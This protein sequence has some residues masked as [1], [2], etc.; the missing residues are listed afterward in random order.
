[1]SLLPDY[2][3]GRSRRFT[4]RLSGW[5]VCLSR[6]RRRVLLGSFII[7]HQLS[8]RLDNTCHRT[9]AMFHITTLVAE[10]KS[11]EVVRYCDKKSNVF[12]F[13]ANKFFSGKTSQISD[14]LL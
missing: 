3:V 11:R 6:W 4:V 2:S 9:P 13:L 1:M 8:E 7:H 12:A 14:P 5:V 10:S